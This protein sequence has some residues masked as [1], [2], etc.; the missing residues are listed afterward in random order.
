MH[1]SLDPASDAE[2][3]NEGHAEFNVFADSVA[4]AR[5]FALTSA[6]PAGTMPP[7]HAARAILPDYPPLLERPL[8][9][10]LFPYGASPI[11][12]PASSIHPYQDSVRG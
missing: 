6:R 9:L 8:R 10:V 7:P 3:L 11:A 5:V 4:A 2:P 12:L 1:S